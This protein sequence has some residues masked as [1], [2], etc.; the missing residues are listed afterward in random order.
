[1][2]EISR[3]LILVPLLTMTVSGCGMTRATERPPAPIAVNQPAAPE[4]LN[5]KKGSIWQS[6]DRNTLFLDNKARNIGDI[7]MVGITERANAQTS[8]N[9]AGNRNNSVALPLV[10]ALNGAVSMGSLAKSSLVNGQGMQSS[11][12]FDGA[13]STDR[14]SRF[15]A[16]VSCVVTQVLSNGNLRI[17]GRQDI[18]I[19][20]ENQVI[21]I[22]GVIRPEDIDATNY[23]SSNQIA[24]A[25]IE[26]TGDGDINDQQ[27]PGWINR[28]F[29]TFNIM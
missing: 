12:Q 6:A 29:S 21:L 24:D 1:M 27:R 16:V 3:V 18:T 15:Q 17:E 7:V 28:F 8:A 19:N 10:D 9:S 20:H 2:K 23:V 22:S 26:L 14:S 4:N 5:P 13:G 11:H 25:R